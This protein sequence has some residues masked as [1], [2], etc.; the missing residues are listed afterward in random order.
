M[1]KVNILLFIYIILAFVQIVNSSFLHNGMI[2][3]QNRFG[4]C[5]GLNIAG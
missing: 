2:L 4:K 3:G 5:E 1:E